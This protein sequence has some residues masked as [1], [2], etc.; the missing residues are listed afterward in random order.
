[1]SH[2]VWFAKMT[3]SL[4]YWDFGGNN[5]VTV[6]IFIHYSVCEISFSADFGVSAKCSSADAKRSTFIGTPYW[7]VECHNTEFFSCLTIYPLDRFC[8]HKTT[9]V[10]LCKRQQHWSLKDVP[11][12]R[13]QTSPKVQIAPSGQVVL[14]SLACADFKNPLIRSLRQTEWSF[15]FMHWIEFFV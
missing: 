11:E 8:F 3:C 6:F 10:D 12:V 2:Y 14:L 1:M 13:D 5:W 4:L 15:V 7:L 9:V